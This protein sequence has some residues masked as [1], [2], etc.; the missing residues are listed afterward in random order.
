MRVYRSLDDAFRSE[1]RR[2]IKHGEPVSPRGLPTVELTDAAFRIEHPRARLIFSPKRRWSLFYALGEF[3]WHLSASDDLRFIAYYS[4]VWTHFSDDAYS[5]AGSCYGRRIFASNDEKPSFWQRTLDLLRRDPHTRQAVITLF[6]SASDLDSRSTDVP[7]SCV[8]QF[9]LRGTSLNL[10]VYMRSND[11]M[12]GFGYD[13]FFFTMLQEMLATQLG[14]E[15]GWYQHVVGS[16]HVYERDRVRAEEVLSE[17]THSQAVEMEWMTALDAIPAVLDQERLLREASSASASTRFE[18]P[19]YWRQMLEVLLLYK[20]QR[21]NDLRGAA[22]VAHRL[23]DSPYAELLPRL[24]GSERR[25]TSQGEA[26]RR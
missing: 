1:L 21:A 16:L 15:L 2:V 8:L 3:L 4:R 6:H 13:V 10:S 19:R 25:R 20:L 23:K 5:I 24:A 22:I 9:L 7:C 11:L 14:A 26:G 18:L 12:L 17:A